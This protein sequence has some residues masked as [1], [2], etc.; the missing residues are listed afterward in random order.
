[1]SDKAQPTETEQK[2]AKLFSG[3]RGIPGQFEAE[4]G[5]L[6]AAIRI[7]RNHERGPNN[8]GGLQPVEESMERIARDF[9]NHPH[10]ARILKTTLEKNFI[11][12]DRVYLCTQTIPHTEA[13]SPLKATVGKVGLEAAQ[14]YLVSKEVKQSQPDRYQRVMWDLA[15]LFE[16]TDVGSPLELEI[17][18]YML[19][20]L[21]E[22]WGI[23]ADV[24]TDDDGYP[25]DKL[26]LIA[27]RVAENPYGPLKGLLL[28]TT[29]RIAQ[30]FSDEM[31][32]GSPIKQKKQKKV[33][34]ATPSADP[35][36]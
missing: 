20:I 7:Y 9:S 4:L 24:D 21:P 26:E 28:E 29:D 8:V 5:T 3:A 19:S 23:R 27:R 6:A 16:A 14:E 10:A 30:L 18:G 13:G 11:V 2:L 31:A 1:M 35:Q 15:D 34:A 32:A 12:G 25:A 33:S 17:G 36:G 22:L